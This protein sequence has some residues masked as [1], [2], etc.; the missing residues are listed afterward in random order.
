MLSLLSPCSRRSALPPLHYVRFTYFPLALIWPRMY[1]LGRMSVASLSAWDVFWPSGGETPW[2]WFYLN[3]VRAPQQ[4]HLGYEL[5][6]ICYEI[7]H[8]IQYIN[9]PPCL[10]YSDSYFN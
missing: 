3:M 10:L 4:F 6:Y 8:R 2:W 1:K 9:E 5:V 7:I